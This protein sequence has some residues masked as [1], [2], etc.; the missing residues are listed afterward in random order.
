MAEERVSHWDEVYG[1]KDDTQLSWHQ[2]DPSTSI[3]LCDV[4]GVDSDSS[5]IDIGGGTSRFAERL[6]KR[7][8]AD[9][10]VL[11]VSEAAL[12]RSRRQ[13]GP[14]SEQIQWIAADVTKWRPERCYDIWHDR[15]VFHFLVDAHERMAYRDRLY[16][17]LQ[18]GSHAIIATFALDGPKKCS[19]LP[20]VRYDPERLNEVLG[21]RFTLVAD[22]REKHSTP[23]GSTQSFQFSLL[24]MGQ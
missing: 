21:D 12:D 13:L 4:A 22:R 16:R 9:I 5:V 15:A 1:E 18:P 19:G 10:S 3:E 8:L 20:V 7:G 6:I 2:D 17:C 23:W 14:V 11:D 24:R